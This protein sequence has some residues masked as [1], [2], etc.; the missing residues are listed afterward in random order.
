[1]PQNNRMHGID[2]HS[3]LS[4]NRCIFVF[5]FHEMKNL[6]GNFILFLDTNH[7]YWEF[8]W[9]VGIVQDRTELV[10]S[11]LSHY[12]I[13]FDLLIAQQLSSIH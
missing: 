4:Y 1:M 11:G 10:P 13:N 3:A 7:I 5:G 8:S 2:T 6:E 9:W 12:P